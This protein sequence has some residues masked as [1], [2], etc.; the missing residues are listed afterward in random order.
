MKS[1][2]QHRG[3]IVVLAAMM[4]VVMFGMIAF[5][6]DVGYLNLVRTQLQTTADAAALAGASRLGQGDVVA[7]AQDIAS[8]NFVAG[9]A[10]QLA[11]ADVQTGLWNS[12]TRTFSVSTTYINAVKVTVKTGPSNGGS[13]GLFFGRVLGHSSADLSASA[14]ATVNPRDIA[15]VIDLSSSMH[16]DTCPYNSKSSSDFMQRIYNDFGWGAYPGT[17]SSY[18]SSKSTVWLMN[19]TLKTAMPKAYPTPDTS[20]TTAGTASQAYWAAYFSYL[21]SRDYSTGVGGYRQIG[22]K[23]Y[24]QFLMDRGRD[25]RVD[26]TSSLTSTKQYTAMSIN[27]ALCKYHLES[28]DAGDLSFPTRE[29]PTHAARRA[30]IAAMQIVKER[31]SLVSDSYQ[32]DWVSLFRYDTENTSGDTTRVMK[33]QSLT[34]NY[35]SV[36]DVSRNLQACGT[37]GYCTDTD[38]GLILAKNHIKAESEGG[39]GRERVN[40]I[41]VLLTDGMPNLYESDPN[42]VDDAQDED[43]TGWGSGYAQNGALYQALLM[44]KANWYLYPVGVGLNSS[45]AYMNLLAVKAGTAT[46]G[47]GF[48]IA[49][50]CTAYENQ[51]KEIFTKIITRPKLR[52]VQ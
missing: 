17:L 4:L 38:G 52:L 44:R 35:D 12:D 39:A 47:K 20:S 22:Y 25:L 28:T 36:I 37:T 42:D 7:V 41:V 43:P 13:T 45:Q 51:L 15:F 50:D 19:N 46:N 6:V 21:K 8:K 33:I 27:S 11:A 34:D 10:G 32:R 40:K 31:N 3:V 9:R 16:N 18:D 49:S 5:A 29:M 26:G 48:T 1:R 23:T 30:I 24:L 2:K 14:I